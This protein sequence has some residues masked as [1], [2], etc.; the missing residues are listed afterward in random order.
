MSLSAAALM[1]GALA[2]AP[3]DSPDETRVGYQVNVYEMQGLEWRGALYDQLTPVARQGAATVWVAPRSA[4]A[5]IAGK[6]GTHLFNPRPTTGREV[7]AEMQ[8]SLHRNYVAS[9]ERHADG[10]VGQATALAFTPELEELEEWINVAVDCFATEEGTLTQ[11]ALDEM[12]LKRMHTVAVAESLRPS[13]NGPAQARPQQVATNIQVPE[14]EQ[15]SVQGE[16]I[17]APGHALIVGLGVHSKGDGVVER[18]AVIEP[19][20]A[21]SKPVISTNVRQASLN[22][23]PDNAVAVAPRVA[24]AAPP[25]VPAAPAAAQPTIL[26]TPS[27]STVIIIVPGQGT[28][29]TLPALPT[30]FATAAPAVQP[31]PITPPVPIATAAIP[32][33]VSPAATPM[34]PVPQ[35]MLPTPL[36]EKGE[37]VPLPPLPEAEIPAEDAS[38]EPR[39]TPQTPHYKAKDDPAACVAVPNTTPIV[40]LVAN[41]LMLHARTSNAD[42]KLLPVPVFSFRTP[43]PDG[44]P[45]NEGYFTVLIASNAAGRECLLKNYQKLL[46]GKPEVGV[47]LDQPTD[48]ASDPRT[49]PI[50]TLVGEHLLSHARTN[51]ANR[52]LLPVPV[53]SFR[54]TATDGKKEHEGYYTVLVASN[55]AG[56]ET[57]LKNQALL[58]KK[59]LASNA[60]VDPNTKPTSLVSTPQPEPKPVPTHPQSDEKGR[61]ALGLHVG[62]SSQP[63]PTAVRIPIAPN[64]AIQFEIKVK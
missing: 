21:Q 9:L 2:F 26:N 35:R 28:L 6:S 49:T 7:P 13:Q 14:M 10:P 58:G 51:Q 32:T 45:E 22:A 43:A 62:G 1:L 4:V 39:G 27:N 63:S 3:Q 23:I 17:V 47:E 50:V 54:S 18:V 33:P 37:V 30:A 34:P 57:L 59:G 20:E 46:A 36:N 31:Q 53:F 29:A 24:L 5:K 44:K 61:I 8:T 42:G 19:I 15:G 25:A 11:V 64:C 56:R 41:Q 60:P 12:R 52:T 55:A 48:D 38:A 16:W 40:D